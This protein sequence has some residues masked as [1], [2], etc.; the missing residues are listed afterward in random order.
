MAGPAPARTV[1]PT[2]NATVKANPRNAPLRRTLLMLGALMAIILVA[3]V[4][5]PY[6]TSAGI[7]IPV[8]RYQSP[9]WQHPMGTNKLDIDVFSLVLKGSQISLLIATGATMI[10]LAV[11]TA[12]GML[13]AFAGGKADALLMRATDIAFSIP[14]FLVLLA[15]T[16][17]PIQS[18]T[19]A[20]LIV[21]IGLTGWFDIARIT[22]GETAA[23]LSR[24]WAMAARSTGTSRLGL[25][26]RHIFPHLVPILTVATT[27]GIGHTIV[28]EAGLMYLG[29][30]SSNA[31]LGFLLQDSAGL[32][33][34]TNWWLT[35]FPGLAII[36]I[37]LACNALGNALRDVFAPEQVHAWPTT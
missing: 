29:A 12:Y 30:G 21:L 1:T 19:S 4:F 3:P 37:V 33:G 6:S 10:A 14:R 35:V 8:A 11:G 17:L 5:A 16:S 7:D 9:S 23:L 18:F 25:A 32:L 2:V 36:C 20:Q 22:R 26:M 31:S 28:L 24:D 13:A 27:L 34:Q 15:A